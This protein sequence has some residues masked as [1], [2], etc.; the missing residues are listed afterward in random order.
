MSEDHTWKK[1]YLKAIYFSKCDLKGSGGISVS[2]NNVREKNTWDEIG[3]MFMIAAL[4]RAQASASTVVFLLVSAGLL[5][6]PNTFGKP[7][8]PKA[9]YCKEPSFTPETAGL[10]L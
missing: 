4:C 2:L 10:D 3:L 8:S 7:P 5:R 1:I 9:L 6:V